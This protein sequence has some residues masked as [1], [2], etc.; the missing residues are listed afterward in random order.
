[1]LSLLSFAL[2]T[3]ISTRIFRLFKCREI[4]HAWYLTADYTVKCREGEWNAYAAFG[5]LFIILYVIGIPAVQFY[6]LYANRKNLY[7]DSCEDLKKQHIVQKEYGSIYEN[8]TPACYY[9]DIVDL[10][11]RLVLTGG[12][13]MMGE[14]SIAQIFL[15]IIIIAR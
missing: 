2:Y 4:Q 3:G 9:Y 8:Y 13:I 1:M 11:R 6:L 5:V 7:A 14:E 12:L 15:G 10:V